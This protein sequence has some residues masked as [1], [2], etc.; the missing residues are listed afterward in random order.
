MRGLFN[1]RL[2]RVIVLL[3]LTQLQ[4]L[5][6]GQFISDYYIVLDPG[7]GGTDPGALG[8]DGGDYPDEKHLTLST[9]ENAD[10]W[11]SDYNLGRVVRTRIGDITLDFNER[12]DIANGVVPDGFGR[13]VED[14]DFLWAF[15]SV[16]YNS[17]SYLYTRGTEVYCYTNRGTLPATDT[18][19]NESSSSCEGLIFTGNMIDNILIDT[20][21]DYYRNGQWFFHDAQ[22]HTNDGI[23][24]NNWAIFNFL[25]YGTDPGFAALLVEFEFISNP[26]IWTIVE[27]IGVNYS[28]FYHYGAGQAI[29][30]AWVN[31]FD[32][33]DPYSFEFTSIA[34]TQ[35]PLSV[36]MSG[37]SSLGYKQT[38]TWTAVCSGGDGSYYCEWYK[39][40]QGSNTWSFLGT[41]ISKS[42]TM[43]KKSFTVKTVVAS[44]NQDE[45]ATK[46]VQYIGGPP[47]SKLLVEELP[48]IYNLSKNNPNP[49][50]PVTTVKYDLPEDSFTEFNIYDML[51]R[52]IKRLVN[53]HEA[54]GYRSVMWDGTDSNGNLVSSGMYFYRLDAYSL[55]DDGE[56]HLTRKMV[57]LR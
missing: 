52:E 33:Y 27:P 55:E 12:G 11:I 49:F 41:G 1:K 57:L 29:K 20:E 25:T 4:P 2:G 46:F 44:G 45:Q 50:N 38:G 9:A 16:H 17:A 37:P 35:P 5:V 42:V 40:Y 10:N 30:D 28:T 8:Y 14:L 31:Y 54:A 23:W 51:G 3:Y 53:G 47:A 43:F 13:R 19:E 22:P 26:D 39:K 32:S 6:F 18:P 15:V 21:R 36:S 34:C 7:H 56:F 24:G 48:E